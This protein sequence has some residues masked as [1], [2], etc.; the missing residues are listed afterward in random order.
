M[1]VKLPVKSDQAQT[2]STASCNQPP[3]DGQRKTKR[4]HG[5]VS[6]IDQ[7]P[8]KVVLMLASPYLAGET[9][10][11]AIALAH[12]LYEKDKYTS[13]LDILGEDMESAA[14]CDASVEAYKHLVDV[15]VDKLLP[16]NNANDQLT[17][18][19]KPSMFSTRSPKEDGSH[20]LELDRALKRI[21]RITEYAKRLGVNVTLEAEDRRWT[22]FHLD[23]YFSL[24][25]EGYT[26]LGTVLQSRLFRTADD[27]SR[28]N[29]KTRVRL[30][31]GI[32]NEPSEIAHT[33][34]P[35]MKDLLVSYAKELFMRGAYVEIATHDLDCLYKFFN[36]VVL[37]GQIPASRFETQFLHG[38]P[39]DELQQGLTN[40]TYFSKENFPNHSQEDLQELAST[41][42]L[43][44]KYLPFGPSKVAGAY[45]RRRLKEN[46]NMITYG[47][48]NLLKWQS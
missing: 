18:S 31:I 17:I 23:T 30:V 16:V 13:T 48:K 27:I 2:R 42:V 12:K 21:K 10:E 8:V 24:I 37:P 35:I 19:F 15:I 7:I 1:P 46:P 28:F 41:G 3:F 26:N 33:Q 14:D 39:R 4:S 5:S 9:G 38:V 44:R 40:G 43:V 47:I 45:C 32:Y 20:D 29:E 36:D 34:K 25:N 22:D 6:M 11:E